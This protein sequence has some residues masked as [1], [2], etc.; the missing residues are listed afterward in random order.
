MH[1]V[2]TLLG[3]I[4]LAPPPALSQTS[5]QI[6]SETVVTRRDINGHDAVT[7]RV[8]THRTRSQDEDRVVIEVYQP[9]MQAR[10]LALNQRIERVTSQTTDGS[11][12]VEVT[13]ERNPVAPADPM[14]V[15][16]RSLTTVRRTGPDSYVIEREIFQRDGNGRLVLVRRETEQLPAH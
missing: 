11:Q 1:G 13:E 5:P 4:V 16:Q 12:T 7:E 14:R 6:V 8:V 2:V 3:A 9:S 15:V 10:R